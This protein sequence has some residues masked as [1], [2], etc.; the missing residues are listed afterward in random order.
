VNAV[1][2]IALLFFLLLPVGGAWAAMAVEV[3]P[4]YYRDARELAEMLASDV[5]PGGRVVADPH[6]NSLVIRDW[7]ANIETIREKVKTFDA[8]PR[9]VRVVAG[10][11]EREKIVALGNRVK[12]FF[13]TADWSQGT[14]PP[15]MGVL[16]GVG[17]TPLGASSALESFN[18]QTLLLDGGKPGTI[19]VSH[20]VADAGWFLQFGIRHGDIPPDAQ[21][22]DLGTEFAVK[23][24]VEGNGSMGVSLTPRLTRLDG[25]SPIS[26]RASHILMMIEPGQVLVVGG[27]TEGGDSLGKR[28][29]TSFQEGGK[30]LVMVVEAAEDAP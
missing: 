9:R 28:F 6:S 22:R 4:V 15:E 25:G 24:K 11:V 21:F 19:E 18:R 17:A 5:S 1:W 7:P 29:L 20:R 16:S 8:L 23:V 27:N 12:W 10:F 30:E 26:L 3:L 14:L 13:S 2:T